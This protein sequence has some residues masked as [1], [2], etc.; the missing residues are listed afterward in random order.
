MVLVKTFKKYT[1][2]NNLKINQQIFNASSFQLL[3]TDFAHSK[4]K[5]GQEIP[6]HR[7]SIV[8]LYLHVHPNFEDCTF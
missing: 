3:T 4:L 6:R 2:I 5:L 1:K 8:F 7:H